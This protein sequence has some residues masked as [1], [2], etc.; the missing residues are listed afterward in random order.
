MKTTFAILIGTVIG[1]MVLAL[2]Q[3]FD[4]FNFGLS[5]SWQQF[6]RFLPV[7]VVAMLISGFTD[8]LL[9]KALVER[10]LSDASGWH[11]IALAYLAGILT[12]AGGVIGLPLVATFYKAGVGS[13]VL[14]TYMTSMTTI[15]LLRIPLELSFCGWQ[16]TSLRVTVSLVLP[17]IAG[18]LGRFLSPW[19]IHP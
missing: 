6:I 2:S 7:L 3:G 15:S 10:W 11:G 14:I 13:S 16:L 5:K 8:V 17:I 19:F 18:I 4:T 9:P 12:P 1:L